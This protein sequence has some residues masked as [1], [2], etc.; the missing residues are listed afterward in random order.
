MAIKF[1]VDFEGIILT[2]ALCLWSP[3]VPVIVINKKYSF[4]SQSYNIKLYLL[5]SEV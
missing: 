4:Y 5:S 3:S 1:Q 2:G